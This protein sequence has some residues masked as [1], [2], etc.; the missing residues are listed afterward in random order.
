MA[1]ESRFNKFGSCQKGD[2]VLVKEG[3]DFLAGRVGAHC[4]IEGEASSFISIWKLIS[5]EP[6]R[7]Y[8]VWEQSDSA[9][10]FF[11]SDIIDTVSSMIF[12]NG[13]VGTLLPVDYR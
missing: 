5:H 12:P 11:T 2:V 10:V 3:D 4:C 7:G 1:D 8:A 9:E 6:D 13:H